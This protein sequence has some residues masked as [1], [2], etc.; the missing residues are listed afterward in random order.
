MTKQTTIVVIG[1]LRVKNMSAWDILA[2]Y[3]NIDGHPSSPNNRY[4]LPYFYL[5]IA[6]N[7]TNTHKWIKIF[8]K[9]KIKKMVIIT[10]SGD[11]VMAL[12]AWST[13]NCSRWH[14]ETF[15]LFFRENK[16]EGLTFHS[17]DIW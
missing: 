1:A 12:K 13:N 14:S 16:K 3:E 6:T 10:N 2:A 9:K 7:Y 5:F 11:M 17:G 4:L 15:L 8:L